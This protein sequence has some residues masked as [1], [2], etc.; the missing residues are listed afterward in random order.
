MRAYAQRT[1]SAEELAVFL[2]LLGSGL[3]ALDASDLT[4]LGFAERCFAEHRR[5]QASSQHHNKEPSQSKAT[6]QLIYM[7]L[8]AVKKSTRR[9][10]ADR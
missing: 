6:S 3:L 5:Y 4:F 8:R 10:E 9:A 7:D 2:C 1:P